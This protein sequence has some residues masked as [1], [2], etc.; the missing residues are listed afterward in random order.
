MSHTADHR[1]GPDRRKLARGG[2]RTGDPAGFAP[3]VLLVGTLLFA[4]TLQTTLGGELGFDPRH[5]AYAATN[6]SLQRYDGPRAA[7]FYEDVLGRVRSMTGVVAA[8]WTRL[9]PSG[10]R[11]TET[12]RVPGYVSPTARSPI[13]SVNVVTAGYFEAMGVS[14]VRGRAFTDDDGRSARPV[15][16]VNEAAA[17]IFW[18]GDALGRRFSIDNTDVTVVGIARDVPPEPG[19]IAGPFVYG[20]ALQQIGGA[21]G[22]MHLVVRTQAAPAATVSALTAAIHAVAPA[23]PVLEARTMDE[24]LM[25]LLGAQRSADT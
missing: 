7:T 23:V 21:L 8:G 16:I 13:V 2:R 11:D 18:K 14:I 1:R 6:V 9:I 15:V 19:A 22:T 25:D 4:R 10:D 17:R 5:V 20:N 24:Q 3:L 12:V